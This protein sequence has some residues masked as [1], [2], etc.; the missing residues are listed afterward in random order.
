MSIYVSGIPSVEV[1]L[2]RISPPV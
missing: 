2:F 1:P